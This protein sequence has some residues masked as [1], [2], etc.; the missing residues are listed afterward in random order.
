MSY[1]ENDFE[2][3]EPWTGGSAQVGD[4]AKCAAVG[5]GPL[6]RLVTREING[7]KQQVEIKPGWGWHVPSIVFK[8]L[9]DKMLAEIG[10]ACRTG[11][12]GKEPQYL[13]VHRTGSMIRLK[14]HKNIYVLPVLMESQIH[15][16]AALVKVAAVTDEETDKKTN[17]KR[18]TPKPILVREHVD[19]P[20]GLWFVFGLKKR[21]ENTVVLISST[22]PPN[23]KSD[24]EANWGSVLGKDGDPDLGVN[25]PRHLG[26]SII[27]ENVL[28]SALG[29][30]HP[31]HLGD[32]SENVLTR[33]APGVNHPRHLGDSLPDS[34]DALTMLCDGRENK[35]DAFII[36]NCNPMYL[37]ADEED[38]LYKARVA[39]KC[40][41]QYEYPTVGDGGAWGEGEDLTCVACCADLEQ[42][43]KCCFE[44]D[45]ESAHCASVIAAVN[46]S[47]VNMTS[48]FYKAKTNPELLHARWADKPKLL[49]HHLG[50]NGRLRGVDIK[51][52]PRPCPC[53]VCDLCKNKNSSIKAIAKHLDQ[54]EYEDQLESFSG[55]YIG[56]MR[57]VARGGYKGARGAHMLTHYGCRKGSTKEPTRYVQGYPVKTKSQAPECVQTFVHH[58]RSRFNR[59]CRHGQFDQAKEYKGRKMIEQMIQDDWYATYSPTYTAVKNRHAEKTNHLICE[60]AL[61]MMVRAQAPPWAW[62]LALAHAVWIYNRLG[63]WESETSSGKSPYELMSGVVPD[64]SMNRVFW[65]PCSPLLQKQQGRGHFEPTS[66][67]TLLNPMRFVGISPTSPDCWTYYDP[68][69]DVCDES[70]HMRF[71]ESHYDGTRVVWGDGP[72]VIPDDALQQYITELGLDIAGPTA[73]SGGE[74]LSEDTGGVESDSEDENDLKSGSSI[75]AEEEEENETADDAPRRSMR[76]IQPHS[77]YVPSFEPA[78]VPYE[79]VPYGTE[80]NAAVLHHHVLAAIAR[81]EE[82]QALCHAHELADAI[83]QTVM[84]HATVEL[85]AF[86]R[87]A[88]PVSEAQARARPDWDRWH[89]A[90]NDEKQSMED[91]QVWT[92]LPNGRD[93]VPAGKNIVKSKGVWK[94]KFTDTGDIEKYKYRLVACGYSQVLGVDFTETHAGVVSIQ[95]FRCFCAL[96]A[97]LHLKTRL[98][99][100]GNAFLE[101]PL[102]EEIY[103]QLPT[104]LGGEVV[105]LRKA[106]YG[107]K[108]AGMIFVRLLA[109]FLREIGFIQSK[110]EP[111]QFTLVTKIDDAPPEWKGLGY[112]TMLTYV[113]DAPTASNST[114]L[115]DWL[116]TELKNRFRK[117]TVSDLRWFLGQR[118]TINREKWTVTVDQEQFCLLLIAKFKPFLEQEF[119]LANGKLK[120]VATP[121]I[122]GQVMSK[123]AGPQ[124]KEEQKEMDLLPYMSLVGGLLYL[125]NNTR[126]DILTATSNCSKFMSNY[127]REMWIAA[128]RILLYLT[129]EPGRS[130]THRDV[131]PERNLRIDAEADCSFADCP[132]TARSRYGVFI[133]CNEAFIHAKTGILK[134]VRTS[135]MDAET[136]ALAQAVMLV[137]PARRILADFGFPQG[138]PTPIG[139]DNNAALLFSKSNVST[140]RARH[141]HVDYHYTRE[142]QNEFKTISVY[143]VSSKEMGADLLTKNLPEQPHHKHASRA[144]GELLKGF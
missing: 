108:Q 99:D 42:Q 50:K 37:D 26:G 78:S 63:T 20:D 120:R 45:C 28:A 73:P 17:D 70:A 131:G 72:P 76:L 112:I 122:P 40:S 144:L 54:I 51:H 35:D 47:D 8:I 57:K 107:L 94:L 3:I 139:E 113:D 133:Y 71:D 9:S 1:D 30:N 31:R 137:I 106:I 110:T 41:K 60:L 81:V 19:V 121:A 16:N 82:R 6:K 118:V 39:L 136:G 27:S 80:R 117:V 116:E 95:V 134:N 109:A 143:R 10:I 48:P 21:I 53:R 4:G 43:R 69:R 84:C 141:I 140:K 96:I 103:M 85:S 128:L 142:Q 105:R 132:D 25:H 52:R 55:D 77:A 56:P 125:A 89:A 15:V 129:N 102:E 46:R 92:V 22:S 7:K 66:R 2:H 36:T 62:A 124:T 34:I 44:T 12:L 88:D 24:E 86:D 64:G 67:G 100:I 119:G 38:E 98:F 68:V 90:Q 49:L 29:V 23:N 58:L 33:R 32:I 130:V 114:T 135:T 14:I 61:L 138:E 83:I 13:L 111:C 123:D 79:G 115:L 104:Y 97:A 59:I 87:L 18:K 11:E 91:L 5:R 127:G 75:P 126:V 101:G 93:D 74:S 65:C